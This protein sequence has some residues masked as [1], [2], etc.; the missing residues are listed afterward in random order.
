MEENLKEAFG[1][2]RDGKNVAIDFLEEELNSTF[3]CQA[4]KAQ[5]SAVDMNV[6][7]NE[8]IVFNYVSQ[9]PATPEI[10]ANIRLPK[11]E[12]RIR[13]FAGGVLYKRQEHFVAIIR[14]NKSYYEIDDKVSL[15]ESK[16]ALAS[17]GIYLLFYA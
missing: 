5:L 8:T 6:R 2:T 17:R 3:T 16:S 13:K 9:L 1:A 11:Y 15:I 7:L 4:C 10:S 12:S 14:R